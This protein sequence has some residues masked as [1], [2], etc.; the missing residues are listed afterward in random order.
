MTQRRGPKILLVGTFP[1]PTGGVSVHVA[2]LFFHLRAERASVTAIDESSVRKRD[3]PNLRFGQIRSY[4]RLVFTTDLVHVHTSAPFFAIVHLLFARALGKAAILTVHSA[5]NTG[6]RHI[7]QCCAVSL[8]TH[9]IYVSDL[10]RAR[11]A[12]SGSVIPAFL[13]PGGDEL[14][15]TQ[16][17]ASLVAK[18]RSAQRL[19]VV[20]NASF[21]ATYA[22]D[23]LYGLDLLVTAFSDTRVRDRY[24]CIFMISDLRGNAAYL[25]KWSKILEEYGLDQ[26]FHIVAGPAH[27][28]ALIDSAD[29]VVRATNTDGDSVTVREGLHFNK[30][31]IASDCVPR[32]AGV[33][34]FKNRCAESLVRVLLADMVPQSSRPEVKGTL[35]ALVDVYNREYDRRQMR[36]RSRSVK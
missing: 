2:R 15:L 30:R 13:A 29:V 10:V 23:D 18:H 12:K 20:S 28:S 8:A 17:A 33:E 25:E 22:G 31:V 24:A 5:R 32:P 7:L 3:F 14:R 9:V 36:S 35:S 19:L 16:R 1:P 21:P 26:I 4:I 34:L 27:F 11:F 6:T